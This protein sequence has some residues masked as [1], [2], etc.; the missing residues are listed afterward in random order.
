MNRNGKRWLTLLLAA[1][2]LIGSLPAQA[3]GRKRDE[4]V[5]IHSRVISGIRP[6]ALE[7]F[8]FFTDP[9]CAEY[10]ADPWKYRFHAL[11]WRVRLAQRDLS[12]STIFAGGDW[13]GN[14]DTNEE[15]IEKLS[16]ITA[17]CE[18]MFGA[19]NFHSMVGNH[20]I[21]EQGAADA[22]NRVRNTTVL[23]VAE[24]TE[25][26]FPGR[27]TAY[28]AF[29]GANT[30]FYVLDSGSDKG[31]MT[32]NHQ[33]KYR[34]SQVSWLANQLKAD[35]PAHAAI[36]MHLIHA[37]LATGAKAEFA[38]HILEVC[39]AYNN[40]TSIAKNGRTYDFTGCTGHVEFAFCG[41]NHADFT[42]VYCGIPIINTRKMQE[43]SDV[44][45]DVFDVDYENR[46][47]HILRYGIGNDREV[48]LPMW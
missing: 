25:A 45:F 3:E 30:R 42:D 47:I 12:V 33:K 26:M 10:P 29:D 7:S 15:A 11:M 35:D 43:D 14:S 41:H 37:S 28:Y 48:S 23:S 19:E 31:G 46:M 20:D 8:I 44:A 13:I 17:S 6:E 22:E 2:L 27:E 40:R 1:L 34:W 32:A 5:E 21:N 18:N 9:H 24:Y 38:R 16:F 39:Q 4:L 36:A